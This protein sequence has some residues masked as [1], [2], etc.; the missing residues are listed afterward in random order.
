MT[1][2]IS[3]WLVLAS[4]ALGSIALDAAR[5]RYGGTLRIESQGAVRALDPASP[6][7]DAGD[8]ALR[9][10]LLPLVFEPLVQM[11][12]AGGI[13]PALATSWESDPPGSRWRFVLRSGVRLH[14]GSALTPALVASALRQRFPEWLVSVEGSTLDV[15][16]GEARSDLLW[17][18]AD[19]RNAIVVRGPSGGI[20]G[21]GPFRVER[22]DGTRLSLAAHDAYWGSRPYLDAV[23]VAFGRALADQLTSIETGQAEMVAVRPTDVRRVT[24]RQVRVAASRSR[25]LFALVFESHLTSAADAPLRRTF[26]AAIDRSAVVRV[27]LQGYGESATTALPAWLSGY[28][29]FVVAAGGARLTRANVA[30]LPAERRTFVLRVT[31]GDA[32]AQAMADRI[33]VDARD[34]GFA[35]TVQVPAGLAPRADLRLVRVPLV[36][37]TPERTLTELMTSL[38]G[39]TV[40]S[41]T[42]EPA[43]P[44][45][46]AIDVVAR[47][48]RALLEQQVL[49]PIVHVPA[50]Y[51]VSE[52]VDWLD[53]PIVLPS[54][55]WNLEN[56]WL[57]PDRAAS[58]P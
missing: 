19:L 55:R 51:A 8:P 45:G 38:G 39:R 2:I 29:P 50:L 28:P 21:T 48:E 34:A 47:A 52:R 3:L 42:R 4:V 44:P 46:A 54:G 53:G 15:H 10:V 14:D 37:T 16:V 24:Q 57:D 12:P 40:A 20:V 6:V 18:L 7:A 27:L 9:D 36:V 56:V 49:V 26:A 33:A 41:A 22:I 25:E 17:E 43:P 13:R 58:R 1:R 11:A 30:S 5:P 31:P 32:V 23:R 35:V